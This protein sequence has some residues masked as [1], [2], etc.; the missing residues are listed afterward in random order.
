MS[1]L[2]FT[3]NQNKT[4]LDESSVSSTIQ[5]NNSPDMKENKERNQSQQVTVNINSQ[6]PLKVP[7]SIVNRAQIK[8]SHSTLTMSSPTVEQV[9]TIES[10]KNLAMENFLNIKKEGF[11]TA[12]SRTKVS[13][14]RLKESRLKSFK[15]QKVRTV[16]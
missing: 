14:H 9:F 8:S 5:N 11:D 15:L 2:S 3:T 10:I 6:S 1:R 7:T 16:L 13:T 4:I 12:S